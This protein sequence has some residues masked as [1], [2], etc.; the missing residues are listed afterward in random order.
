MQLIKVICELRYAE[1]MRALAPYE[2]LYRE[3]MGKEPEDA[4]KWI[5]PGLRLEDKERKRVVVVDPTRTTVDIEQPP[6]VGYCKDTILAIFEHVQG[7]LTI[8]RIARW[9]LRSMWIHEYPGQ[10]ESLLAICKERLIGGAGFVE[11]ASDVG[12]VLDYVVDSVNLTMATGP[13]Q[14]EQL[15]SQFLAFEPKELPPVFLYLDLD[16]ADVQTPQYS[17]RRL[18]QLF[19]S[20]YAQ[21][22]A[23]AKEVIAFVGV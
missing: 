19:D 9:G 10:F 16:T 23:I 15:K 7:L 20:G 4:D 12:L 1:R 6:N 13:M 2:A 18:G 3:V 11:R 8:P 5:T 14:I 17:R 22:D 21:A